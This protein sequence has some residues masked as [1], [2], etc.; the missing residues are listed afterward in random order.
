[1]QSRFDEAIVGDLVETGTTSLLTGLWS[2][3]WQPAEVLRQTRRTSATTATLARYLIAADYGEHLHF[4]LEHTWQTAARTS[5][6]YGQP[7]ANV[8]ESL[9]KISRQ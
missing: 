1:M 8:V 9:V 6:V 4:V 7:L 5:S 3:G 2:R